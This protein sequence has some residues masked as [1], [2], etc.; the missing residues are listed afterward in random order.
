[1]K[2]KNIDRLLKDIEEGI[3]IIDNDGTI[4]SINPKARN[5]LN[6]N[7]DYVG[8]KYAEFI[9]DDYNDDFH[10][11]IIEAIENKR[12]SHKKR[13]KYHTRNIT[14]TLYISSSILRNNE[15]VQKGIILSFDDV[16]YEE[17]LKKKISDSAL[18]FIVL[19]ALLSIWM[20]MCAIFIED[21]NP[22]NSSLFGRIIMYLP[23]A[24]T[25]LVINVFGFTIEELGLRVKGIKENVI[26]DTILTIIAVV[27]MCLIKLL[28]LKF[29]P[30]FTFYTKNNQFFDFSKYTIFGRL[31]YGVCVISQEYLSRG[32]V[33]ECIR[34]IVST[35]KNKKYVD[36]IAI[37]VSSL[38]FAALHIYLGVTYMIGAFI[39]LSLFGIIYKKQRSIW[40]L[41]IPHF[42]LGMMIEIL[43]FTMY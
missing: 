22:I 30:S 42:I 16:S 4:F 2:E 12:I 26:T 34:R 15:D 27:I 41:C 38:Y 28:I 20:F 29:V 1:M 10:Q 25:P 9:D 5:I 35:D 11:M 24:F 37:I 31:E 39:L 17:R 43:G 6:L 14:K 13:I 19:V 40:G 18:I 7:E 23:L 21:P 33:Y 32:L 3:I 8:R 36:A